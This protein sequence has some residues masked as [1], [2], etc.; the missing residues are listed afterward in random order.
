MAGILEHVGATN[1]PR[2]V[3][4]L[5][6]LLSGQ[7]LGLALVSPEGVGASLPATALILAAM[8][9]AGGGLVYLALLPLPERYRG[10]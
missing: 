2:Q 9:F 5:V 4:L 6:W 10:T 1:T 7:L 8:S 3:T